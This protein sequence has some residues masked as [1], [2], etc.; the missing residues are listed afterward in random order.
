MEGAELDVLDKVQD[1]AEDTLGDMGLADEDSVQDGCQSPTANIPL[2]Q[3]PS[4]YPVFEMIHFIITA[5][6]SGRTTVRSLPGSRPLASGLVLLSNVAG[7]IHH[8]LLGIPVAA[9][10]VLRPS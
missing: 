3:T 2:Y 1:F 10:S 4:L 8:P 6:K 5:A 7:S 9:A